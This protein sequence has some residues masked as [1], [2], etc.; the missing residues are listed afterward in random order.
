LKP[1]RELLRIVRTPG[2]EVV[3]DP[4][5]KTAGRGAYTCANALCVRAAEKKK[6]LQRA[7]KSPVSAEAF[8]T[9]YAFV[10]DLS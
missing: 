7:L 2:G 9:L 5:G 6:S 8:Q 4:T 3:V 10:Q 1:K